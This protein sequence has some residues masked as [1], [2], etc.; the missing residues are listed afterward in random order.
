MPSKP[1][2][3]PFK[4]GQVINAKVILTGQLKNE[5]IAAADN[6]TISVFGKAKLGKTHKIKIIRAKH[7]IFTAKVI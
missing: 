2:P 1:L 3:K 6:R 5:F 7:N 4:K